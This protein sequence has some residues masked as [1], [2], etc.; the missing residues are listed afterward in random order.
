[1]KNRLEDY[2]H[3]VSSLLFSPVSSESKAP[4]TLY[5]TSHLFLLG[6]FN[7]RVELPQTHPLFA[8]RKTSEFSQAIESEKTREELKEYD[9][10]TVEK[11]KGTV[12][13]GLREGDF[14]KFKCSYK[15][16]PGEVDLYRYLPLVFVSICSLTLGLVQS[17]RLHG[18]T[19]CCTRP[20]LTLPIHPKSQISPTCC[21]PAFRHTQPRTM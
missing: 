2:G 9:Q 21:T 20:I 12:F 6:D 16:K 13:V 17:G 5:D 1:V 7:F 8:K 10:L 18:Q 19:E 3:I 15:Y 14:W 11:R 4:S